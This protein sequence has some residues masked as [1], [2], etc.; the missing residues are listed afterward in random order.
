M[1]AKW[2]ANIAAPM[3]LTMLIQFVTPPAFHYGIGTVL[4]CVGRRNAMTQNQLNAAEAPDVPVPDVP[5]PD[6]HVPDVPVRT[7]ENL[8]APTMQP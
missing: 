3:C 2:Y 5:V 1:N 7:D 6:V 8:V 4:R